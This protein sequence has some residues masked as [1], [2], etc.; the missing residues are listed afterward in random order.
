MDVDADALLQDGGRMPTQTTGSRPNFGP[1]RSRR[2]GSC[3]RRIEFL[4]SVTCAA[5]LH[6]AGAEDLT[7]D[8]AGPLG[9]TLA[10]R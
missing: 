8:L 9:L 2:L 3:S 5:P 1:L 7:Q 6:A 4:I 10:M